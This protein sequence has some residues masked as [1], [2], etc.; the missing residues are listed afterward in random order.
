MGEHSITRL[1][2]GLLVLAMGVLQRRRT[3]SGLDAAGVAALLSDEKSALIAALD[4]PD[5]H[6][7]VPAMAAPVAT[8]A[9]GS[10][11][12]PTAARAAVPVD[13]TGGG[14]PSTATSDPSPEQ[15]TSAPVGPDDR[16]PASADPNSDRPSGKVDGAGS[17]W[18][19]LLGAGLI[20]V[21]FLAWILSL[22]AG[23]GSSI[24]EPGDVD[25]PAVIED[26]TDAEDTDGGSTGTATSG[27]EEAAVGEGTEGA[28]ATEDPDEADDG[29]AADDQAGDAVDADPSDD[30]EE[31]ATINEEL[32]LDPVTFEVRS[33]TITD[34][35]RAVLDEAAAYLASHPDVTVEIAGH[36]DS[37]G[38]SAE[39]ITLSQDR[40]DVVKAYLEDQG[41]DGSR[42]VPVGYGETEPVASN[43]TEAGKARN[44]RIEFIIQ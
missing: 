30:T 16:P 4:D 42:L 39:N 43:E 36:T 21:L 14:A 13:A 15:P 29:Q 18:L 12:P 41:I 7:N 10:T 35:G 24:D 1:L 33:A 2:P 40:A 11:V 17:A 6:R 23:G 20:G 9:T 19:W 5:D 32:D 25:L 28:G 44:R 22:L 3:V 8:A 38:E 34:A 31:P 26:S 37:D 27:D